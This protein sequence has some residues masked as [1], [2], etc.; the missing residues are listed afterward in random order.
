MIPL[1]AKSPMTKLLIISAHSS[2]G[3]PGT[4]TL[5][6][7]LG[8]VYFIQG[9]RNAL[10]LISCTCV[11]CQKAYARPLK[12][13]MGLLPSLRTQP[14]P[15]FQHCGIDFAGPL[16]CC[17]GYTRKPTYDDVYVCIFVCLATKAI[18]LDLCAGLS[19]D[20]FLAT[21]RRFTARRGTPSVIWSDNGTNFVGARAELLA[22]QKFLKS[23]NTQQGISHFC[24]NHQM[25]WK[26]IPPRAPHF[27]GLWEAG[28]RA[29]KTLLRKV[30]QAHPLRND[31][32]YTILTEVEA[33]LN[34]RPLAPLHESADPEDLALT[35]GHFLIQ[36]PLKAPPLPSE[37]TPPSLS[38]LPLRAMQGPTNVCSPPHTSHPTERLR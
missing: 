4:E 18:H 25:E 10:K 17:R 6:V 20:E 5:L 31:E 14:A 36:R 37:L 16:Q 38:Q 33:T 15:P 8:D 23:D 2:Y 32:F 27:G 3:H 28:V 1:S 11:T 30:I 19:T 22:L 13:P 12:P 26:L 9:L 34:S 35:P 29:M 21:L 7:I 24:S